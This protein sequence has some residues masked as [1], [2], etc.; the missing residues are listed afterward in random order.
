VSINRQQRRSKGRGDP[1]VDDVDEKA[2]EADLEEAAL[3]DEPSPDTTAVPKRGSSS[4][5]AAP[6]AVTSARRATPRQF[7]HEVNVEMRK[8]VWPSRAETA[9]Y[10]SVVFVTLAV[11][12]ALIFLLDLAFTKAAGY[13]FT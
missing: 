11:L 9:N 2:D 12:M 6:A 3:A 4:T 13:I 5:T 8:V 10:A 1:V 7:L